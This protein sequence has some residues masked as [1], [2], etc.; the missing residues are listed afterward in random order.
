M[1]EGVFGLLKD[2]V[3]AAGGLVA[4]I[5]VD[6]KVLECGE[7]GEDWAVDGGPFMVIYSDVGKG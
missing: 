1:G 6:S 4:E 2:A 7:G 3:E 5:E